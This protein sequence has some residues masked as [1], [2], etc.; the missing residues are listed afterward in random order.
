MIDGE[1][2]PSWCLHRIQLYPICSW[3]AVNRPGGG[4][5]PG[6]AGGAC[7]LN[8]ESSGAHFT[9]KSNLAC[10]PGLVQ[11]LPPGRSSTAV[12]ITPAKSAIVEFTAGSITPP[13][14]GRKNRPGSAPPLSFLARGFLVRLFA[15]VSA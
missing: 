1:H 12:C 6:E 13:G 15:T 14:V 5:S 10:Q 7:P 3:I 8:W 4:S 2:D 9:V 11:E